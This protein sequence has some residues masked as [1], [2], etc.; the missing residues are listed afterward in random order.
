MG[1]KLI[2]NQIRAM[3]VDYLRYIAVNGRSMATYMATTIYRG[4]EKTFLNKFEHHLLISHICSELMA[5][6]EK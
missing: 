3:P 5:V 1:I 6:K 4:T 2:N